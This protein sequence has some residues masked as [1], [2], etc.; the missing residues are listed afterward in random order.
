MA[1][2]PLHVAQKVFDLPRAGDEERFAH[3]A[4]DLVI[5]GVEEAREDLLGV[6]DAGDVVQ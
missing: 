5:F 4:L 2:Q 6:H 1:L 3:D